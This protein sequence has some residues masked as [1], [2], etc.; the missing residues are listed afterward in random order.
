MLNGVGACAQANKSPSNTVKK[1]EQDASGFCE[2]SDVGTSLRRLQ[3]ASKLSP[4]DRLQRK[5]N[6]V[7]SLLS[8]SSPAS[9]ISDIDL[10]ITKTANLSIYED[11]HETVDQ[12][13]AS[14]SMSTG[15]RATASS[16]VKEATANNVS[17]KKSPEI[18]KGKLVDK[19]IADQATTPTSPPRKS[20]ESKETLPSSQQ[21]SIVNTANELLNRARLLYEEEKIAESLVLLEEAYS[22]DPNPK[23]ARKITRLKEALAM[24]NE[25]EA[26]AAR[27]ASANL[28][29][30]ARALFQCKD[31][32]GTLDL[33]LQANDLCPSDKL[34]RRIERLQDLIAEEEEEKNDTCDEEDG[35]DKGADDIAPL[36]RGVANLSLKVTKAP[37][38]RNV[39][40]LAEGF[41]CLVLY[42]YQRDGV[43]WL[44]DLH[45]TAPGGILADDMG[46]GKTLQTIAFL[47]GYL[48]S[49]EATKKP[50][51]AMILAPVSVLRTWQSEFAKWSPSIRLVIYYEMAKNARRHALLSFQSRGG[52]LLTT[53]NMLVSGIQVIAADQH[54]HQTEPST[55]LS[56][57]DP[58][59]YA[60]AFTYDYII[61]DEAHRIKNP[62]TQVAKAVR[63][64]NCHH[65]LLL[66]GTA[67]QNNL[68]E[69][70]SLFDFT[71]AGCLLGSQKTFLL[72]Y[73]KPILRSRERD[74][75]AAERLHGNL[76]AESLNKIIGPFLLRRTKKDTLTVFTRSAMPCKNEIVVWVYL[77]SLQEH[78]YRSFLK[79][80][81]VK[82][83]LFGGNTRRSP[84]VEL[85]ILKKLCDHPRLLSAHQCAN[86]G[87]D[88]S[89][90]LPG[91]E[92]LAPSHKVLLQE[93][94]KM[95]FVVRLLEHFQE[96]ALRTGEPAHRTLIFSQSLRLLNMMEAAILGLNG[97]PGRSSELPLHRILRLDGQLKPDERVAVLKEFADDLSYT[98]MLLTTQVG[99]VGLTIT[100][101]DRVVILD[102]SWNPSV[103]AQAVDRVYRIG[104]HSNVVVYRLITCATVEEKIYR[105]QVFKDSVIRQ[106]IG[107]AAADR[108]VDADV[109]DPYRYFTRQELVEL[110]SLDENAHFSATQRQLAE[111][112]STIERRTYPELE[113]HLAFL[114]SMMDLVFDISDHDILFSRQEDKN[115]AE[116][117]VA[118]R[119]FAQ[120]RLKV[121]E[122]A[123]K[124]EAARD[125]EASKKIQ[126]QVYAP[127]K[128]AYNQPAGEIF[129]PSKKDTQRAMFN[130]PGCGKADFSITNNVFK[131]GCVI[132]P[133]VN[134][135]IGFKQTSANPEEVVQPPLIPA[136]LKSPESSSSPVVL[137]T[138]ASTDVIK[139]DPTEVVGDA[140]I[141]KSMQLLSLRKSLAVSG[142]F[143]GD[144]AVSPIEEDEWKKGDVVVGDSCCEN[145]D[146][147][148]RELQETSVA[149]TSSG[150]VDIIEASFLENE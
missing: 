53:Y 89:K 61:L 119:L 34:K 106:T 46:L 132:P 23:T 51:T 64:L 147:G 123:L 16:D 11:K 125:F 83:F 96:E 40:E 128:P 88:V 69:L 150:L 148:S 121:G 108:P 59:F 42:P 36:N 38:E 56:S 27:K 22:L 58:Q 14:T 91:S 72:Q 129:I 115:D 134:P 29:K 86:L 15:V 102:P 7:Q 84:L 139:F 2:S 140:A 127:S 48:L 93:S 60:R 45:K 41:S 49:D 6:R 28:E 111:L 109:T 138:S 110:F 55:W 103:D 78:I 117:T 116:E 17:A 35:D 19:E 50:R 118:E 76:M 113:S 145:T 18:Q 149:E 44:W 13:A 79:L 92:I 98:A 82:E 5:P 52:I 47:T 74:A 80:D 54:Y 32:R 107:R 25:V 130:A 68:R 70:W 133:K 75:S 1:L 20:T 30:K 131:D 4:A 39:V 135:K 63:T 120:N 85:T 101:A 62:S 71:H 114:K 37:G 87:L 90:A 126:Q 144:E 142:I 136:R 12:Q 31:Y 24:K 81:H 100:S 21:I 146:G 104:Q 66:T 26:E 124:M 43:S 65:R 105:R 33:L 10:L 143:L 67:V 137:T 8:S 94:G 122:A 95:A 99:G 57:S 3:R 141:D 77:S 97:Q 112:H 9:N 73:E